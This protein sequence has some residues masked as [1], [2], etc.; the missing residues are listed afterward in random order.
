MR[1]IVLCSPRI[2]L[3]AASGVRRGL[4][5]AR[6]ATT[7]GTMRRCTKMREIESSFLRPQIINPFAPDLFTIQLIMQFYFAHE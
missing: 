3:F 1:A 6:R 5:R 2:Q 7:Y 4:R